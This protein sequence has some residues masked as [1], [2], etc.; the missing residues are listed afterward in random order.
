MQNT[1]SMA[2]MAPKAGTKNPPTGQYD[3]STI[4]ATCRQPKDS[5]ISGMIDKVAVIAW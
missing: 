2:A 4:P 5:N 3:E 1:I